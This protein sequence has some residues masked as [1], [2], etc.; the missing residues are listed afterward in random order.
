M[1]SLIYTVLCIA[2]LCV[3]F[4]CGYRIGHQKPIHIQNPIT[5]VKEKMETKKIE[6][7]NKE[8]L[9]ELNTI[10]ENIENYDGTSQGQKELKNVGTGL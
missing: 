3:G 5:T 1:I 6:D 7:A 2:C 9:E 10:L 4:F 8:R